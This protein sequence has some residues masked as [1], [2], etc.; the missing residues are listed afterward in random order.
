M[1]SDYEK[2]NSVLPLDQCEYELKDLSK[3]TNTMKRARDQ[4]E[5]IQ[6]RHNDTTIDVWD[7][8]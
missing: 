4:Y 5:R 7:E 1:L 2:M 8:Q 3:E 6:E